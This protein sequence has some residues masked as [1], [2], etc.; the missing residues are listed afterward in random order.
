MKMHLRV[1]LFEGGWKIERSDEEMG[2]ERKRARCVSCV[3]V[4]EQGMRGE[5][6]RQ[7]RQTRDV[8]K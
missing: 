2:G 8:E 7:E 1:T 5:K 6:L 3:R 4:E